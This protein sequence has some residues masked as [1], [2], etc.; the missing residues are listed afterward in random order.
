MSLPV[1]STVLLSYTS[2]YLW[3]TISNTPDVYLDELR[4]ELEENHGVSIAMSTIWR[5]LVK[6]GY[7]MKK[8]RSQTNWVEYVT[9]SMFQ[10]SR[11]ALERSIEK[12]SM[13]AARIGTYEPNQL[14]FVD[15]STVDHHTTYRGRAWAIRG[16]K[17]TR[18]AFFC[19]GKR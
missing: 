12:R 7:S 6:G 16:T 8:A 4:L 9:N 10:L 13:F 2:Q 19:R 3:K 5:T 15:E 1:F 14:V 17:A 18:K 11:T